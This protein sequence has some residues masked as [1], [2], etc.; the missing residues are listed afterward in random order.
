M[1]GAGGEAPGS[2]RAH[3]RR[4]RA[5]ALL[6]GSGRVRVG[7]G[8]FRVLRARA[9]ESQVLGGGTPRVARFSDKG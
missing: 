6:S 8:C 1:G 4:V 2:K 9:F 5:G 3:E 7:R